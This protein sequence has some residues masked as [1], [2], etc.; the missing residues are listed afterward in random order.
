[1]GVNLVDLSTEVSSLRLSNPTM[2][3]SGIMGETSGS[4]KKIFE[5]GAA[6]VVTKSVGLK[7]REGFLNPTFVE[8]ECGVLNCMGLPN[9]GIEGFRDE[10]SE[11]KGFDVPVVGS[12]F[13]G[14]VDEFVELGVKMES[15]GADALELNLSCPHAERYGL[16]IGSKAGLVERV[17][18]QVKNSVDIPVFAKLSSNL[19]DVVKIARSAAAGGADALVAI[20]TVKAMKID[21]DV[22]KPVLSNKIGGYSGRC[23][24]PI[25]VRC[26]FEIA[27]NVDIPIIGVGGVTTG[28]DAVEYFMAGAS[29][30]QI[31]TA[32]YYRGLD[33]FSRICEE[34][35][36]WMEKNG[37]KRISD[38]VGVAHQ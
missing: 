4:L 33:V 32:V 18:E 36:T 28:L 12:I 35:K 2:L 19:T 37:F 16:E 15:F 31:G 38:I 25:G 8:L 14:D 30:V 21:L 20:N 17:V 7:P 6:A 5:N 34:I 24:K 11:L 9:P 1:M 26:V 13:G 29:A 10:M 23:I 27:E 3:A 22:K